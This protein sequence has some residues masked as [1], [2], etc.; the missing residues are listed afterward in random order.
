MEVTHAQE[1]RK[2]KKKKEIFNF[3]VVAETEGHEIPT[4]GSHLKFPHP[5]SNAENGEVA[6]VLDNCNLFS[7]YPL[8]TLVP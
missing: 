5:V 6:E 3:T 4:A 2:E 1:I 8:L 7:Y